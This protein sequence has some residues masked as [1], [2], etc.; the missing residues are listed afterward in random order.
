[1]PPPA[2][3]TPRNPAAIGAAAQETSGAQLAQRWTSTTDASR[4]NLLIEMTVT[5]TMVGS[6]AFTAQAL[7]G[8]SVALYGMTLASDT[9]Y[10]NWVGWLGTVAGGSRLIGTI[11]IRFDVIMPCMVLAWAWMVYLGILMWHRTASTSKRTER[12]FRPPADCAS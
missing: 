7:L 5:L 4:A 10:P 9:S 2:T 12:G 11:L 1:M 6:V 3:P 8:L